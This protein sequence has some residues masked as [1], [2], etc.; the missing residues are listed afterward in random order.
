MSCSGETPSTL[1]AVKGAKERGSCTFGILGDLDS[2]IGSLVDGSFHLPGTT[3]LCRESEPQ[4]VQMAGSLFEQASFL[5]L[6]AIVLALY[7]DAVDMGRVSP[8]HAVIE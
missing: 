1:E 5:L 7:Q 2:S 3:K 4:S 8:R 6:E